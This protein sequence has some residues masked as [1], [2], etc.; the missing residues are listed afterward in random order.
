MTIEK[1]DEHTIRYT[2][3]SEDRLSEEQL[4]EIRRAEYTDDPD[5]EDCPSYSYEQ[6][7]QMYENTKKKNKFSPVLRNL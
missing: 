7:K 5:D 3:S 4:D 2:L 6:L 1:I